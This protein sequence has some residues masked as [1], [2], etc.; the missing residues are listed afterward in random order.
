MRA[1]STN[2]WNII[3]VYEDSDLLVTH[4]VSAEGVEGRK[5]TF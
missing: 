4:I 2:L 5:A 1:D 3:V